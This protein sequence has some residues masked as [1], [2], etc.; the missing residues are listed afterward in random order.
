M[1]IRNPNSKMDKNRYLQRLIGGI[2]AF[3]VKTAYKGY[4]M[5]NTKA[6]GNYMFSGFHGHISYT[7]VH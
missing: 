5:Q 2:I 3:I 1:G 4:F 6:D 7:Y